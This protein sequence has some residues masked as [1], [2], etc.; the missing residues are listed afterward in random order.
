MTIRNFNSIYSSQTT[1]NTSDLL[2]QVSTGKWDN[3]FDGLTLFNSQVRVAKVLT[4]DGAANI[5][6]A[7]AA[8][9]A[10]SVG[11]DL[12]LGGVL[13]GPENFTIDP[14]PYGNDTGILT[15]KG[16]TVCNN[17]L[18]AYKEVWF[19]DDVIF[20]NPTG[21]FSQKGY[22]NFSKD[23]TFGSSLAAS[24]AATFGSTL[25]VTGATT[26]NN[27]LYG[28]GDATFGG[29]LAASGA[30][31][32]GSTLNVTGATTLNN[33]LYGTGDATFGGA[34]AASGA[35]T[36]GGATTLNNT[37]YGAGAA[38][39][40]STLDAS[41]AVSFGS[42]LNV[43]GT[44]TIGGKLFVAGDTTLSGALRGPARFVID[45]DAYNNETG[46]VVVRGNLVSNG[47]LAAS[48]A[49]SFGSTAYVSGNLTIGLVNAENCS[50]FANGTI[51]RIGCMGPSAHAFNVI[52]TQNSGATG[53]VYTYKSSLSVLG[54][55]PTI[56]QGTLSASGPVS[57]GNTLNVTG[58]TTLGGILYGPSNL[59]ID[60]SPINDDNGTVTIRGNLVV[61]GMT[62]TVNSENLDVKDIN[63]T[64]A[65]GSIN[66][67]ASN[68]AGLSIELG[69]DLSAGAAT[70]A[71][72]SAN[73]KYEYA[74]DNFRFDKL[75]RCASGPVDN[76]DLSNKA[77]V[78][79]RIVAAASTITPNSIGMNLINGFK[80]KVVTISGDF[81]GADI[82]TSVDNILYIWN[83][84]GNFSVDLP[85]M[86][87][88]TPG[89]K[90]T[91]LY[92]GMNMFA[93][94]VTATNP[95][96]HWTDSV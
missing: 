68:G 58:N 14:S 45:P 34:L 50:L 24:G 47:S 85:Y 71:V 62:T 59:V 53:S 20:S 64:L 91:P 37:L 86:H 83:N 38:T 15:I 67:S 4:V 40:G 3:K 43:A 30:V 88:V 12:N 92:N 19:S 90:P 56:L 76:D 73:L 55:F 21:V 26:L 54:N 27:T 31:S 2:N 22:S 81:S 65:K 13:K 80:F 46:T 25:N 51:N 16:H 78:D 36:V 63:L 96:D 82:S 87:G 10:V 5:G 18:S 33:T 49:V 17:K 94:R 35:V 72:K 8:S 23:A 93:Y 28:T 11:G 32:F 6:G 77:Y 66:G 89:V 44:G 75:V 7:L 95:E 9:G 52:S 29:A 69:P 41:G 61:Q 1:E 39:F 48:G 70:G 42:T 57:F 79:A 60:P 84:G 74:A